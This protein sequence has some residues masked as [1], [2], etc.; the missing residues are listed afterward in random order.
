MTT[1]KHCACNRI[2]EVSKGN[3]AIAKD[4]K[5][6]KAEALK[7]YENLL[8][9]NNPYNEHAASFLL[10]SIPN[11]LLPNERFKS[12]SKAVTIEEL[13]KYVFSLEGDKALGPDGFSA[14]FFQ[15]CWDICSK[16]LLKAVNEFYRTGNLIKEIN[17]THIV[18]APKKLDAK[19]FKDFRPIIL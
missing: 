4:A 9:E 17:N 15:K 5:D 11:N 2:T 8:S 14:N 10:D 7:Y 1:L 19:H 12:L 16:D 3:G 6:I 13:K 18:L